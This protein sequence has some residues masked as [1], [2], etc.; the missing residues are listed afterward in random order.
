MNNDFFDFTLDFYRIFFVKRIFFRL[1]VGESNRLIILSP[2]L[3]KSLYYDYTHIV[4]IDVIF[5]NLKR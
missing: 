4:F 1:D 2:S 5:N 3:E